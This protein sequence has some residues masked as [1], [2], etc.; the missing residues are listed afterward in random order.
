MAAGESI[1]IGRY[2]PKAERLARGRFYREDRVKVD[3]PLVGVFLAFR[4]LLNSKWR[5]ADTFRG[6][7]PGDDS[8]EINLAFVFTHQS[9]NG[10]SE[11]PHLDSIKREVILGPNH[12]KGEVLAEDGDRLE[13]SG[14]IL[15]QVDMALSET[16]YIPARVSLGLDHLFLDDSNRTRVYRW[17][18]LVF[19]VDAVDARV[20]KGALEAERGT[21]A[22]RIAKVNERLLIVGPRADKPIGL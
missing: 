15:R 11:V 7:N 13:L 17:G 19:Q 21:L 8:G 12:K 10:L 22:S 20:E 4:G 9:R 3:G 2:D 14:P 16:R 1:L 18:V 5:H 6:E